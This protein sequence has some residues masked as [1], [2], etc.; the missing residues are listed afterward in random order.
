MT[1]VLK[2]R[3]AH[4]IRNYGPIPVIPVFTKLFDYIISTKIS[5]IFNNI[6]ASHQHGF[7]HDQSTVSNATLFTNFIS[8]RK[9]THSQV[10]AF[11][12]DSSR[13]FDSINHG[14][15][16]RKLYNDDIRGSLLE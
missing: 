7:V 3:D 13:A 15:L 14:L 6:I 1:L 10:D 16:I 11:H 9:Y 4:N 2:F 12:S 8:E 5:S